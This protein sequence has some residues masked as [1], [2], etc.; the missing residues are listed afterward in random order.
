MYVRYFMWQ[1]VGREA[2]T[3]DAGWTAGLGAQPATAGATP[4]EMAGR[5]VYF[6]LPLLLG[7]V[8][9]AFHVQRDWRRALAVAVLFLV[10]G[11]GIILYLNQTPFQPRERDYSYVASFFAFAL[12]VGIGATGLVELAAEAM[13][14][15]AEGLRRAVAVAL[16][17]VLLLAVPGWMATENWHDHD[18]SGQRIATDFA[19]NLLESTAPNAILFTNG[20][21]DTFPLWY[22]QEVMG[23]R[24]DVRVVNLSLLNTTW[25]IRQL[26]DQAS[27]TSA[28]LPISLTDAE[29]AA[30]QPQL[31]EPGEVSLPVDRQRFGDVGFA[32]RV[33]DAPETM[34]WALEGQ[35]LGDGRSVLYVADRVVLDILQ[36]VAED[37]WQRPVYFA[38]TVARDSELGLQAF[39]QNEGLARRVVPVRRDTRDPE[40]TVVPEITLA[41]LGAFQYRGLNDPGVYLDENSRN[42]AD[43]YRSRFGAIAT[44]LARQGRQ[45]EARALLARLDQEV[46]AATVPMSFGSLYTLAEAYGAAGD[47]PRT[48]AILR[49]AEAIALDQLGAAVASR[50]QG[51]VGRAVQYVQLVQTGYLLANAPE[52]AAAV[53]G[54]LATA[55]GDPSLR[56]SVAEMRAASVQY[57][58]QRDSLDA[59]VVRGPV[60]APQPAAPSAADTATPAGS[61]A[62]R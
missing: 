59:A 24:R 32:G 39:F 17:A 18:R 48:K 25:Y 40:G 50:S 21:N 57:R 33:T 30:L 35:P 14:R 27:R 52:E 20:D 10:T 12:W 34:T 58:R 4:S 46:S 31:F 54:R 36:S 43:G 11:V 37:G 19:Q 3:Q 1:F 22:L 26:R 28:P 60:A 16:A 56:A 55:L 8:G 61:P 53:T 6:G 29:I 13:E 5:N 44:S 42:M 2:D 41:R 9:I 49:R 23:V 38:S 62:G 7:L 45:A 47:V 15:R 51:E